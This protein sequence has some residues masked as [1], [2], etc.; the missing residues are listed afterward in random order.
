MKL[1]RGKPVKNPKE[2]KP[3]PPP[4]YGL[5]E[6]DELRR[7]SKGAEAEVGAEAEAEAGLC[8]LPAKSS[9][10]G[11]GDRLD[12]L[13]DELERQPRL[14]VAPSPRQTDHGKTPEGA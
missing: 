7:L 11:R 3:W 14:L 4:E 6:L 9:A 1:R 12:A 8:N 5:P 13:A 10:P 2:P